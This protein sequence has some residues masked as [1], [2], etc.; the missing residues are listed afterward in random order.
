MR[1]KAVVKDGNQKLGRVFTQEINFHKGIDAE[2]HINEDPR[3]Y[4]GGGK[5]A[6][7]NEILQEVI[8]VMAIRNGWGFGE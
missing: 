7:I 5:E 6:L 1:I 3:P 2:I 4:N 8:N